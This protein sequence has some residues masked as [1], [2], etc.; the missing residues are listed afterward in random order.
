MT[1]LRRI[2][3]ILDDFVVG[4][5][6]QQLLDRFLIG[7]PRDGAFHQ[8][9]KCEIAAHSQ[10]PSAD[11]VI[12][13]KDFGLQMAA[14]RMDAVANAD[15]IVFLTG[16]TNLLESILPS[17]KSG[18]RCFVYGRLARDEQSAK[19]LAALTRSRGIPL[20]SSTATSGSFRLP[21]V[22]LQAGSKVREALIIVQGPPLEAELEALEGLL[23][24]LEN[25]HQG[26]AGLKRIYRLN[27]QAL[28]H[29]MDG[30]VPFFKNL[31]AAAISRSNTIQGDP[32]KDGR[33]QDVTGFGLVRGLATEPRGWV[34]EHL[35][36]VRSTILVL[37][38]VLADFN[39]SIALANG[40]IV[41]AQL[42]RPPPP[43]EEHFSRLCAHIEDFFRGGK[44]PA[45]I[46]RG[47][48]IAELMG[49]MERR[50]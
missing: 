31:L 28:G 24:L 12:R 15:A 36:G 7:Y 9:E 2:A 20:S 40:E 21:D 17:M 29:A 43:M 38:G 3:F 4:K 10:T 48:L 39:F 16:N 8:I 44:P 27:E 41:S 32:L 6:S 22:S 11:L 50:D 26:E 19:A 13:S 5:P 18:A 30:S 23:P 34:I 37:N 47:I 25:R 49:R 14:S 1:D 46:E 33:T 45:P 42:Y 35:D